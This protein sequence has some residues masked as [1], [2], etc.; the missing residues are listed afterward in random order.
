MLEPKSNRRLG[1]VN[2]NYFR[3]FGGAGAVVG[4]C[5]VVAWITWIVG[6]P[7]SIMSTIMALGWY[8]VVVCWQRF[9]RGPAVVGLFS[10]RE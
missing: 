2:P 9:S 10:V 4:G 8:V 5:L 6:S 3:V 7:S 1:G